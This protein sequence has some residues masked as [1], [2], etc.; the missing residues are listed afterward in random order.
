MSLL[1]QSPLTRSQLESYRRLICQEWI[2]GTA[3]L[4]IAKIVAMEGCS[5]KRTRLSTWINN[6]M[7]L[8]RFPPRREPLVGRPAK[9]RQLPVSA[10]PLEFDVEEFR[11]MEGFLKTVVRH[12]RPKELAS[13]LGIHISKYDHPDFVLYAQTLGK[14]RV[15]RLT[16]MDY[17]LLGLY[18]CSQY[19]E[20]SS[21]LS[22]FI[23]ILCEVTE[24]IF[25]KMHEAVAS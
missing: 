5:I 17:I 25:K 15:S 20:D 9:N 12:I 8:G 1:P 6:E 4:E 21:Q 14:E 19:T 18:S 10:P 23:K 2:K 24:I 3:V 7:K 13:E 16:K 11:K 22:D